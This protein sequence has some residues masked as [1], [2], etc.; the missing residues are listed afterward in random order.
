MMLSGLVIDV[1]QSIITEYCDNATRVMLLLTCKVVANNLVPNNLVTRI[2]MSEL[3]KCG[4]L[5]IIKYGIEQ[6]I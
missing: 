6:G 1:Q 3:I 2:K 4:Y 5:D